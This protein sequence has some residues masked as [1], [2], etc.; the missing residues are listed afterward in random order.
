MTLTL[1]CLGNCERRQLNTILYI[2]C[3]LETTGVL[4]LLENRVQVIVAFG[5]W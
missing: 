5:M 1:S 4:V 2:Y 3:I